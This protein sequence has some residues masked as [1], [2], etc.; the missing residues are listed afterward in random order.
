MH[1]PGRRARAARRRARRALAAGTPGAR[2]VVRARAFDA[3]RR[4][5]DLILGLAVGAITFV[6]AT[7]GFSLVLSLVAFFLAG[8][9]RERARRCGEPASSRVG[10]ARMLANPLFVLVALPCAALVFVGIPLLFISVMSW[11]L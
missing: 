11:S 6:P 4:R 10:T 5:H 1:W 3:T 2:P 8:A 9:E 7:Y